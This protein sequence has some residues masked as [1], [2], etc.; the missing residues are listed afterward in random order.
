[1]ALPTVDDKIVPGKTNV[2]KNLTT[3]FA[4]PDQAAVANKQALDQAQKLKKQQILKHLQAQSTG[5]G[6][7]KQ[8]IT[9]GKLVLP[10][11]RDVPGDRTELA[12][13]Q[14]FYDKF[15]N[16]VATNTGYA[17]KLLEQQQLEG[18]D[19]PSWIEMFKEWWKQGKATRE[20]LA[21]HT[22]FI[23]G[24]KNV[25]AAERAKKLDTTNVSIIGK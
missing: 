23:K 3:G 2:K 18:G 7:T 24:A 16:E 11:V 15:A 1:M 20:K 6:Q 9:G 19:G 22:P 17:A 12:K 13:I 4:L 21:G 14:K 25:L 8:A 5:K 10:G